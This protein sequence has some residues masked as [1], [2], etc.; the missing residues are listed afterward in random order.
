MQEPTQ[1]ILHLH[2]SL[3]VVFQ[4]TPHTAQWKITLLIYIYFV[5]LPLPGGIF[6]LF[7][8]TQST[9]FYMA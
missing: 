1:L 3:L 2:I 4:K 6:F 9:H 7:L 5:S 8:A